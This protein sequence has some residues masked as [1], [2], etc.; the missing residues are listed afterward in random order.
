MRSPAAISA[1][2]SM[3]QVKS[4]RNRSMQA[5]REMSHSLGQQSASPMASSNDEGP[6]LSNVLAALFGAGT[7]TK[8]H[9]AGTLALALTMLYFAVMAIQPSAG[10]SPITQETNR[11]LE[12]SQEQKIVLHTYRGR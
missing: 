3:R 9:L 1:V 10:L 4:N 5:R 2:N 8:R 12:T 6:T 11:Q 7:A